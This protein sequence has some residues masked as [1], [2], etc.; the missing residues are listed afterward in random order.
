[1]IW[2]RIAGI[3]L[4]DRMG[5][6]F[7]NRSVPTTVRVL[8][9]EAILF[10]WSAYNALGVLV[11]FVAFALLE[12][13]VVLRFYVP[14]ADINSVQFIASD[15]TIQE[16]R[17]AGLGVKRPFGAQLHDWHGERPVLVAHQEECPIPLFWIYG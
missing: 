12:G 11:R 15:A 17:A 9:C 5:N 14:A 8:P 13:V 10:A 4:F 6:L 7:A 1:M 16:L 2:L 3:A